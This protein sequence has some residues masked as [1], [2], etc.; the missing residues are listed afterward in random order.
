MEEADGVIHADD[1]QVFLKPVKQGAAAEKQ[2]SQQQNSQ[3]DRIV[4]QGHVVFTQP[5]RNGEGAKLVYTADDGHYVLTGTPD[6]LPRLW[7][8]THGTTTGAALL[9]NSQDDSVEVSGGKSSVVTET[10]APR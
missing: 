8:S 10:R 3:I 6:A 2:R 1:G 5:G 7:D 9:F 4:A